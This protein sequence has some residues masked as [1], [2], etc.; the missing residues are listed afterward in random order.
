[1]RDVHFQALDYKEYILIGGMKVIIHH[2]GHIVESAQIRQEHQDHTK[3]F[4]WDFKEV[5][6]GL[7]T[8]FELLKVHLFISE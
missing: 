8:P 5:N 3:V 4:T 6:D 1:M 2:M 7:S